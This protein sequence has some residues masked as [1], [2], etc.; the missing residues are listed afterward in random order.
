MESPP[1]TV[2]NSASHSAQTKSDI[3]D[4][5]SGIMSMSVTLYA[6]GTAM[7]SCSSTDV[8]RTCTSC[9]SVHSY[10]FHL[11]ALASW[12]CSVSNSQQKGSIFFGLG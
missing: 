11:M 3:K 2:L 6:L 12:V 7:S 5:D 9:K 1:R 10:N 8:C 4:I